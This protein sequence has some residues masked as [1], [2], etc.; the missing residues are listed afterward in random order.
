MLYNESDKG[1][2]YIFNLAQ[3]LNMYALDLLK[4]GGKSKFSSDWQTKRC[5]F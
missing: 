4:A 3:T 5:L 1:F 2:V